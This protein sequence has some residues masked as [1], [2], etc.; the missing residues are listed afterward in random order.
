MRSERA[1]ETC[2]GLSA[3][4]FHDLSYVRWGAADNPRVVVCVHGLTRNARDFDVIAEQ[5]SAEFRV[6]CPDV[7]GRGRSGWLADKTGYQYA[8]YLADMAV[9]LAHARVEAADWIGTSMGGLIGM[10]LAAQPGTPI[11]RLVMND[12]GPYLPLE[13][14]ER[15]R[16]Y[17]GTTMTFPDLD[18]MEH[19]LR[20]ISAGF[21]PLTDAQWRH[22]CR[23]GARETDDGGVAFR[24]DP[25]IATAFEGLDADVDLWPVWAGV[26]QPVLVMRGEN[27]DLLSADTARRMAD[28]DAPTEIVEFSAVG[29]APMLMSAE[30][31]EIV[32]GWM[33]K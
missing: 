31:V 11:R 32:V 2:R 16:D 1:I 25:G 17:V 15:I 5:L 13:A 33:R 6:I 22:L 20:E 7:V 27:S 19:H 21:G 24:Y 8:Q 29:H 14:L 12:V 9:V 30:Q 10:L 3:G 4:G 28:R 26:T 18:A 23:H